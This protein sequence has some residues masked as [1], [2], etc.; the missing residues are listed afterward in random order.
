M[1]KNILAFALTIVLLLCSCTRSHAQPVPA[2][3]HPAS[4]DVAV[5]SAPADN[6]GIRPERF[7]AMGDGVADDQRALEQAMAQASASGHPLELTEG[8]V[9][10]FTSYL[11]VPGGLIIHGNGAVLL[12]DIQY[13]KLEQ[14]RVAVDIRGDSNED[15]VQDIRLENIVFQAAESC[16]SNY[17]FRVMRAQNVMVVGCTFDCDRNDW[18]RSAADIYGANENIR[19]ENCIFRQLTAGEAGGIWVRNWTDKAE[20]RGIRFENCDFYKAGADEVLAV[21]G[22][23]GKV[24]DVIISG[25]NFYEEKDPDY[26]TEG[27]EPYW[28]ITLGQSGTTDVW[29]ENCTVDFDRCET[30]FRMVGDDTHAIVDNCDITMSQPKEMEKHDHNSGANPMLAQ[31]NGRADGSTTI[32]NSRI[33]LKG[34][35]GRRVC[36]R[37]GVLKNNTMELRL[38]YGISSTQEVTGNTIKGSLKHR[39]FQ[40]CGIVQ[41]NNVSIWRNLWL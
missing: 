9:Y 25:C 17:M 31:G 22:W 1:K 41:D 33:T 37:L 12:S 28:L 5:Q 13:E 39:T 40:D 38:G 3:D 29:M 15:R 4:S 16:Q 34:D 20:S 6:T 35:S 8:A 11:R 26:W 2:P 23:G 10:R 7:G 14:D 18:C 32:Q 36:Y 24:S 21:W 30:I 27:Y 19:F